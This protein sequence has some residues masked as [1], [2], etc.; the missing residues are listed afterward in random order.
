MNLVIDIGNTRAKLALFKGF[1]FVE[2]TIV[3]EEELTL[4]YVQF[5]FTRK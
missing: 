5:F 3:L 4:E 1:D 2:K